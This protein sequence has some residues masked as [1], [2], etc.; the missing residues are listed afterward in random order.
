MPV[1]LPRARRETPR[2]EASLQ[3]LSSAVESLLRQESFSITLERLERELA[4]STQAFVW[5]PVDLASLPCEFP[6]GIKSCW[7]FHLR[8]NVPSGSH[9]HPNSVQHMVLVRGQGMS[10]VG[11]E[12]RPLI[13]FASP[14]A[15]LADRWVIIG[16]NVPHEFTPAGDNMTVV[17]FHTSEARELVE[18]DSKTGEARFY[19]GP[20][21]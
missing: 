9:Y 4:Q 21:A 6:R 10:D 12:R 5:A 1:T 8:K 11:G 20:D 15:S 16:Q 17:S 18:I 13:P 7:I 19:E 2:G 3:I 14:G